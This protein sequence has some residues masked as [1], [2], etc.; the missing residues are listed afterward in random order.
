[1]K[2]GVISCP[3][4]IARDALCWL[5]SREAGAWGDRE[6]CAKAA[7]R[8]AICDAV[9]PAVCKG[10]TRRAGTA[11]RRRF[12]PRRPL[13]SSRGPGGGPPHRGTSG[14][15]RF[16]A[17]G[18]TGRGEGQLGGLRRRASAPAGCAANGREGKQEGLRCPELR[19]IPRAGVPGCR[20]P[21]MAEDK[22]LIAI[23]FKA[24]LQKKYLVDKLAGLA[25]VHDFPVPADALRVGTLDSL[26]SL[27]DDIAK[28]DT[29]AEA[30]CFKFYRQYMDLK[31]DQPP[32]VNG[33]ELRPC[34]G[35]T[36]FAAYGRGCR[37]CVPGSA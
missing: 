6:R 24:D 29:L 16:T 23:A 37:A 8:R 4:A 26:M 30:A 2:A 10:V 36:P 14:V 21:A 1:M 12:P 13:R 18:S 35:R 32:T 5:L 15:A 22:E 33:S 31:G 17:R 25:D 27:S 34:L 7:A 20:L 19:L 28:M 11:R 9:R 3:S